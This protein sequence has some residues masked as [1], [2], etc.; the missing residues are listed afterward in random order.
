MEAAVDELAPLT[1]YNN[2][3]PSKKVGEEP[4]TMN[5]NRRR[6]IVAVGAF[7]IATLAFFGC[8]FLVINRRSIPITASLAS[9]GSTTSLEAAVVDSSY[10]PP[11]VADDAPSLTPAQLCGAGFVQLQF[12]IFNYDAYNTYFD[13]SSIVELAQTGVY[14]CLI[15]KIVKNQIRT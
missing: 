6:R 5:A 11:A 14:T 2:V 9:M 7:C 4:A 1:G 8:S 12:N 13:E 15:A 10:E 3:I